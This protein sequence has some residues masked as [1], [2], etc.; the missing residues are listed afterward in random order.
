M[1]ARIRWRLVIP[2]VI[3]AA[4]AAGAGLPAWSQ[5]APAPAAVLAASAAAPA[6]VRSALDARLFQQ[7]LLAELEARRGQT[8][9][10]VQLLLD[11]A[12]RTRDEALF[13]RATEV[14]LQ[15][16]SAEQALVAAAAWRRA[17]PESL[18]ALRTQVQIDAALDRNKEIEEPLRTLLAR[19]PAPERAALM[20]LLPRLLQRMPDRGRSAQ[21]IDGVLEPYRKAGNGGSASSGS[22][23]GDPGAVSTSRLTALLATAQAWAMAGDADRALALAR[24][25]QAADA[26]APGPAL[27]ALSLMSQRPAAEDIVRARLQVGEVD[28][29]L[30]MAYA[31]V[32]MGAQR[33]V[34]AS[35]QLEQTIQARPQ[36]APPRLA[37]A[38]LQLE[39]Q[40]PQAAQQTLQR[41]LELIDTPLATTAGEAAASAASA[42][43]SSAAA[44]TAAATAADESEDEDP[45]E[46]EGDAVPVDRSVQAGRTQAWLLLAQAAEQRG[47]Y[48][49][50]ERWLARVDDPARALEVQSLRASLLARR[51]RLDEARALLR[52]APERNGADARTKLVAEAALLRDARRWREAF[53]VLVGAAK[54]FPDDPDLLYEQAMMAEKMEQPQEMEQLLRRVIALRPDNAHAHNALGYALADRG[55]RLPEALAL[56]RRALELAPGDP[57]ITD[58]L[59]W[60][61]YR[62][63]N[64][65]EALRLLRQAYAA[66]PDVEIGAHLG[67]V[68]WTLGQHDEARR[69][70]AE[71]RGRDAA[72]DVLRETLARLKVAL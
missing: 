35:A 14:A 9:S 49:E 2:A 71:S 48:D 7:L 67:E 10:A 29:A 38:A 54:R 25:A 53:E 68:L 56:V 63:G 62:Q 21:I 44:S 30:R 50:A 19:T 37:L 11:A 8:A 17:L 40:R 66:R 61:E 46:A 45:D 58:S 31:R 23:S 70:W 26:R 22:G 15:A 65:S 51:G 3:T 57:F 41:Y 13:R 27:L 12:R 20:G 1:S 64:L 24:T 72:N 6:P 43:A 60:I 18:A 47:Q 52:Q 39:L 36:A 4:A 5:G 42:A 16:R 28:P 55:Q 69:V 34:E 33:L 32:L 59:G